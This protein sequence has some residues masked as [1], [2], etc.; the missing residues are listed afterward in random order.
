MKSNKLGA[1]VLVAGVAAVAVLLGTLSH[2]ALAGVFLFAGVGAVWIGCALAA[3]KSYV[4]AW[5]LIGCGVV[6][7]VAALTLGR[8][9]GHWLWL[10]PLTFEGLV[11]V[12]VGSTINPVNRRTGKA[13]VALGCLAFVSAVLAPLLLYPAMAARGASAGAVSLAL[14][15]GVAALVIAAAIV[16]ML[17]YRKRARA[18]ALPDPARGVDAGAYKGESLPVGT[19]DR[20]GDDETEGNPPPEEEAGSAADRFDDRPVWEREG[21]ADVPLWAAPDE[22]SGRGETGSPAAASEEVGEQGGPKAERFFDAGPLVDVALIGED[23]VVLSP[24]GTLVRYHGG[25]ARRR[26]QL[27]VEQPLGLGRAAGGH[28]AFV[29]GGGRVLEVEVEEEVSADGRQAAPARAVHSAV[30][31]RAEHLAVSRAGTVLVMVG[32]DSRRVSALFLASEISRTVFEAPEQPASVG[33]SVDGRV[34]GVG[35]A[36]GD[37]HLVDVGGRGLLATWGTGHAVTAVSGVP[38]GGWLV[39]QEDERV[40]LWKDGRLI[41]HADAGGAVVTLDVDTARGRIAVGTSL[42]LA[43]VF[44]EG[45]RSVVA[46]EWLFPGAIRRVLFAEDGRRVLCAAEQGAVFWMDL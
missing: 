40:A 28:L 20:A 27:Q 1:I 42:G 21:A 35:T 38:D 3:G 14:G 41:R 9:G 26:M 33:F 37:L 17:L 45:L 25:V 10:A 8:M 4:A 13:M 36:T 15:A 34:I 24:A 19:V 2:N 29:D 7:T 22:V 44:E 11:L 23:V 6:L 39:A 43:R 18:P 5:A 46:N 16:L 30:I 32:P 31:E 12:A